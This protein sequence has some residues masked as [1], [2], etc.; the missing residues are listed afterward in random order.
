MSKCIDPVSYD[1]V[2]ERHCELAGVSH[3]VGRA[4]VS[5]MTVPARV[6]LGV[7]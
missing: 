3:R 7:K 5:P 4:S 2:C 6:N 1:A